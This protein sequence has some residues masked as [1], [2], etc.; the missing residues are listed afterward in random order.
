[1]ACTKLLVNC[2]QHISA[3]QIAYI[4]SRRILDGFIIANEVVHNVKKNGQHGFVMKVDFHKAFNVVVWEYLEEMKS[5]MS[6]R[7]R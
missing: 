5:Y 7:K 2:I 1:M 4:S 3:N 6:F